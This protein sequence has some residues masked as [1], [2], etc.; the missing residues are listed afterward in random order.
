[1]FTTTMGKLCQSVG[2]INWWNLPWCVGGDFN[3]TRFPS[4]KMGDARLCPAMTEFLD[5]IF[6]QGLMDIP[7]VGGNLMQSNNQEQPYWSALDSI[8]SGPPDLFWLFV[9]IIAGQGQGSVCSGKMA[10]AKV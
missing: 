3:V 1:V 5:F 8:T 4:E 10:Q 9:G 2:L 6:D 7:L